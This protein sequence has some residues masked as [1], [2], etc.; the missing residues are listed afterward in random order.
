MPGNDREIFE[1][2]GRIE[3]TMARI[4]ERTARVDTAYSDHEQRLRRLEDKEAHRGGAL[5]A[6]TAIGSALGAAAACIIQHITGG[7]Q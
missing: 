3:T 2:L 7:G 5:A 1:R 4:D 6:L